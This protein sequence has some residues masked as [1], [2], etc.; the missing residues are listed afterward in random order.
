MKRF[1]YMLI[2]TIVIG[3][4]IFMGTKYQVLLQQEG[5]EKFDLRPM[6]FYSYG[7]YFVIGL[8]LRLPQLIIEI[9]EGRAW[10]FDWV[11]FIAIGLLPLLISIYYILLLFLPW[12]FLPSL[13]QAIFLG[14]PVIQIVSNIVV[15]YV[16]L[17]CLKK[18][19]NDL[20]F[21]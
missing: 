9:I 21:R 10:T 4:I 18:P 7:F 12:D 14:S 13:S 11:K 17:D 6:V 2:W 1:L 16:F 5:S 8:L 15:G 20:D 19:S 3:F